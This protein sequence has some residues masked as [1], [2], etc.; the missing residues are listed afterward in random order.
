[1]NRSRGKKKEAWLKQKSRKEKA[2]WIKAKNGAE[3]VI[4]TKEQ[5]P[6][7]MKT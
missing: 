6:Q 2:S 3:I 1:M 7:R 4:K 5:E